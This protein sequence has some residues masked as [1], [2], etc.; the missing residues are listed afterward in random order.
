MIALAH[1]PDVS[2][3]DVDAV[4]ADFPFTSRTVHNMPLVFLDSAASA[5]SDCFPNSLNSTIN[6]V[7]LKT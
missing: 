3:L 6:S 1:T 2:L 5:Q 4:R 7:H